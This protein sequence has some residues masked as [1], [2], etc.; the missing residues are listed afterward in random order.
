MFTY[1]LLVSAA[2]CSYLQPST[3]SVA[4]KLAAMG[5]TSSLDYQSASEEDSS[6]GRLYMYTA[7]VYVCSEKHMYSLRYT[8]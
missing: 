5:L 4:T 2:C 7:C 3:S 1:F 8:K 6:D